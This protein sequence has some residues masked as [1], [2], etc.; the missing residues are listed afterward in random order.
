MLPFA[1][2]YQK[3]MCLLYFRAKFI[4]C[5]FAGYHS[6]LPVIMG[7]ILRIKTVVILGGSDCA[8]FPEIN[9]GNYRKSLLGWFTAKSIELANIISPVHE[10]MIFYN[11]EYENF[12]NKN[13]GFLAFTNA[14]ESNVK[15]IYNGFY[16]DFFKDLNLPR[17]RNFVAIAAY[18]RPA[19]YYLKGIDLL[20]KAA[21]KF[22][23]VKFTVIG[24]SES[25]IKTSTQENLIFL[26][27]MNQ[28]N[29]VELLNRHYFYCQLSISEGFPN[30]LCE[31]MLCG[32]IPVVSNVCSMPDIIG[33]T[34]F[35]LQK[36][37]EN[38]FFEIVEKML[39]M[40]NPELQSKES[41]MRIENNFSFE[42]RK[43]EL[44]KL[45]E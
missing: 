13:Q 23:D 27:F 2:I 10:K 37:D 14:S 33:N 40:P 25:Y 42:R 19:V 11:Y 28:Q 32:C 45:L 24:V 36:R 7:K 8:S 41:R 34:G 4:I 30:A 9:Y 39:K 44:L 26:P 43:T 6:L 3:L 5:Q 35:V 12:A 29:L 16:T 21:Q 22:N 1:I 15:V 20:E 31:A 17:E 38:M 18:N